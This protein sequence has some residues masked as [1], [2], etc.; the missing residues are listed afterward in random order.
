MQSE[1]VVRA[2]VEV[3][4][5]LAAV[6]EAT[7]PHF[8]PE[9]VANVETRLL[10]V[11]NRAGIG[12][13]AGG[14]ARGLAERPGR[15]LDLGCGTGF[16]I[17][18]AKPHVRE[19]HGVDVTA[20]MLEKVDQSGPA[21][22]KLF[23]QDS[24]TF[25]PEPATYDVVTAYSFLHHLYDVVPTFRT[26]ATALRPG[27]IF[28]ADLEPNYYFWQAIHELDPQASYDPIVAREIDQVV[29]K[30]AEMQREWG[31]DP[32]VFFEAEYGKSTSRGFRAAELESQLLT[33]GFSRVEI[34]FQWFLGQAS[35][36][37]DDQYEREAR[38]GHARAMDLILQRVLPLSRP[39]YKYLGFYATK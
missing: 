22:I 11:L 32:Q 4:T 18:I 13:A 20:A 29:S 39:L 5:R 10:G 12:G 27:G 3:H 30:D 23:E 16:M 38:L 36:I 33:A 34:F 37:N 1:R 6:Y 35:L 19:I 17:R 7:E 21:I 26:A 15:L 24:G 9:N 31:I 2:N 14:P 8:R 28:Y 25:Q